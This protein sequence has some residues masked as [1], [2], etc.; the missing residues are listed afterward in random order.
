MKLTRN[1]GAERH[2]IQRYGN[3]GFRVSGV[4]YQG[5][6]IVTPAEILPWPITAVDHITLDSLQALIAQAGKVDVCLLGCG[7]SM[8]PLPRALKA[9]LKDAGLAVDPM[10]TGAACRTFNVLT[11]ERRAVM[12]ALIAI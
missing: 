11:G 5:S 8:Q 4:V 1:N 3:G 9:A 10:D 6:V 2:V 12:A 7:V